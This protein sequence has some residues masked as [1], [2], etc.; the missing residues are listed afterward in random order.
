MELSLIINAEIYDHAVMVQVIKEY[1]QKVQ[2]VLDHYPQYFT[3][4]LK[5][6]M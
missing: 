1:E 5:E 3:H 2:G 6:V 4:V